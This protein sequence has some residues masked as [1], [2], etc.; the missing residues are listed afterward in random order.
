[1]EFVG[2]SLTVTAGTT[3]ELIGPISWNLAGDAQVV[4]DGHIELGEQGHLEETIGAP[5]TGT[6]TETATWPIA[7]PMSGAEPGGLGLTITSAYAAG[8]MRVERGHLPTPGPNSTA[9]IARWFRTTTP[10]TNS[11]EMDVVF[12][13]DPAELNGILPVALSL[14]VAPDLG[15]P[16]TAIATTGDEPA[17]E[18]S[19]TDQAPANYITAFD[20][21]A[22]TRV[23]ANSELQ[24]PQVWPTLFTD[25][26]M[27]KLPEGTPLERTELIDASGRIVQLPFT[28][29]NASGVA[30]ISVPSLTSGPY[31]LRV[32]GGPAYHLFH[33]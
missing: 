19:G 18:L 30:T 6:G 15:G 3:L 4:N 11:D 10:T 33:P 28:Q 25:V 12:H 27:V 22:T 24:R 13:Y 7:G 17:F 21:D 1:M 23:D 9:S 16:W 20:L 29:T 8:G 5:I 2:G 31:V 26:L 14:F 32:N